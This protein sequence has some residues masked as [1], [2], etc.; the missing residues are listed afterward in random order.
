MIERAR[1]IKSAD[2]KIELARKIL[3]ENFRDGQRWI[4]YCDSQTQLNIVLNDLRRNN[5]Q[6][7]EYHSDMSGDRMETLKYFESNGGIIVSIKCLD[8]GVDIPSVTHALILAS[9]KN[10]REFIQRRGRVLRKA[11]NKPIAF[12]YDVL[13]KPN[14]NEDDEFSKGIILGEMARAVEFGEGA[15][16]PSAIY[17][18]K[19]ILLNFDIDYSTI[20]EKGIEV[21]D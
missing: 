13:V 10:P 6:A 11:P 21:D 5:F 8:E 16:N 20:T 1:I 18:L 4:V 12:I 19:R 7:L 3:L 15:Q 9:S 17:E 2:N 14:I